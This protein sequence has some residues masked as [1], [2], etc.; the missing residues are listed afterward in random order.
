MFVLSQGLGMS[1][2]FPD[3]CLTPPTAIPVPYPNI[4]FSATSSLTY[5]KVLHTCMPTV[6]QLTTGHASQL[7]S[8]GVMGFGIISHRI[9]GDLHYILG[10]VALWVGGTPAQRLTSITAQNCMLVLPNAAG[11]TIVPSQLTT[12]ALC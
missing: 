12:L 11:V 10:C 8:P 4:Q 6:N 5:P 7:D 2:S 9:N 3:V 1:L